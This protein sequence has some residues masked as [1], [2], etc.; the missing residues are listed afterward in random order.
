MDPGDLLGRGRQTAASG[1]FPDSFPGA[2]SLLKG[3]SILRVLGV[4]NVCDKSE[5]KSPKSICLEIKIPPSI[6][7]DEVT[8][9]STFLGFREGS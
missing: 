1:L 7:F 8:G 3:M 2:C 5:G 6:F 9:K 4:A